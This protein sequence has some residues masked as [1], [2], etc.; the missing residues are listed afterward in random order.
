MPAIYGLFPDTQEAKLAGGHALADAH[1]GG[2]SA[3]R[4]SGIFG[5]RESRISS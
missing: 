2:R 5:I 3:S 1:Q 4:L